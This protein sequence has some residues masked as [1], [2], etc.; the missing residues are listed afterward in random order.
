MPI[1]IDMRYKDRN[2][3]RYGVMVRAC[4]KKHPFMHPS[5][6]VTMLR[7]GEEMTRKQVAEYLG[8]SEQ[9]VY[10]W[11]R[12]EAQVHIYTEKERRAKQRNAIALNKKANQG[13]VKRGE[14]WRNEFQNGFF[15]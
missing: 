6:V 3:L 11:E 10:T 15:K 4:E 8:V 12:P 2:D 5:D 14:K 1:K 7:V 13:E 9:T